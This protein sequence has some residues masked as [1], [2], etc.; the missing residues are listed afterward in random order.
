MHFTC[1]KGKPSIKK[2]IQKVKTR[3]GKETN[4]EEHETAKIIYT[5]EQK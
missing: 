4:N 5:K 3:Q 2:Y 1:T